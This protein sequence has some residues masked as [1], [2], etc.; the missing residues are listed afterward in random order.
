MLKWCSGWNVKMHL[1]VIKSN[2]LTVMTHRDLQLSQDTSGGR[3]L[4]SHLLLTPNNLSGSCVS[5]FQNSISACFKVKSSSY[6]VDVCFLCGLGQAGQHYKKKEHSQFVG[7]MMR[8]WTADGRRARWHIG[9]GGRKRTRTLPQR[10]RETRAHFTPPQKRRR[11]RGP[12]APPTTL[13][14]DV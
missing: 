4:W 14:P 11:P 6:W 2:P 13:T 7:V 3:S 9:G 1:L 8:S 10:L 12:T 5:N